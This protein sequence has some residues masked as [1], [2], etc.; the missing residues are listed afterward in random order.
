M[1]LQNPNLA[2]VL[3]MVG[4][5]LGADPQALRKDLEAGKYDEVFRKMNSREAA[6]L[7]QIVN[8]PAL[9]Q[10]LLNTPQAQQVLR[11]ILEQADRKK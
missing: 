5:K 3:G 10:Q 7:Q 11:G 8:N 6:R 4:Q 2:R 1:D 9:A